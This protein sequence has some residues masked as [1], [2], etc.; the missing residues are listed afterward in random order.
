MTLESINQFS[1]G[2]AAPAAT[3][4]ISMIASVTGARARSPHTALLF[5]P[6]NPG[7]LSLEPCIVP[8]GDSHSRHP[9]RV[10]PPAWSKAVL[11]S[12]NCNRICLN[13]F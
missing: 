1:N 3:L 5:S 8:A 7:T 6:K 4:E 11:E 2:S 13:R 9:V 12:L 10:S